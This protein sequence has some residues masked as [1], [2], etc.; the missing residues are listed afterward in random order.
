MTA[1]RAAGF[2]LGQAIADPGFTP[3]IGDVEALLSWIAVGDEHAED[4]E[5]ALLRLG[6]AAGQAAAARA[7][8]AEPAAR[9]R[10]TKLVGR[11][12][13]GP[14]GEALAGSLMRA[15]TDAD[16]R[17]RRAAAHALGKAHPPG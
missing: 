15:V 8:A 14:G 1:R 11:I 2:D 12:A 13:A 5:R 16:E 10:L 4:A 9:A 6:I 7:E 17:T 3:R